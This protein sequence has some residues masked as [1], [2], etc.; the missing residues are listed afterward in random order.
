MGHS[1]GVHRMNERYVIHLVCY[2]REKRGDVLSAFAVL[3]EI[4]KGFHQASLALFAKGACSYSDKVE[5]FPVPRDQFGL[6]IEGVDV[7]GSARHEE[8]DNSLGPL[9]NEG[10]LCRQ[11]VTRQSLRSLHAGQSQ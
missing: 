11:G 9:R 3:L 2:V 6:V 5:I 7:T 8:E 1:F 10:G 4:P